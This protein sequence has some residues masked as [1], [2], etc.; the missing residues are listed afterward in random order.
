MG[1]DLVVT[2]ASRA[3]I[4]VFI[5]GGYYAVQLVMI[6]SQLKGRFRLEPVDPGAQPHEFGLASAHHEWAVQNGFAWVGAYTYIASLTPRTVL[7]A[8]RRKEVLMVCYAHGGR[9]V[10]D[11]ETA[12]EDDAALST[13]SADA[14]VLYPIHP[15]DRKQAF[16]GASPDVL[17][18]RHRAGDTFLR[19]RFSLRP[20]IRQESFEQEFSRGL[21]RTA[22]RVWPIW[23]FPFRSFWWYLTLKRRV[24]I[25][26]GEQRVS[27]EFDPARVLA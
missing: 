7:C 21:A 15:K 5:L 19:K 18:T 13:C 9:T 2:I 8:W 26:V 11:L 17:L 10:M 6:R 25:P 12:Y 3:A 24:N 4:P 23:F 27:A 20:L 1:W 16:S 22:K 14:A